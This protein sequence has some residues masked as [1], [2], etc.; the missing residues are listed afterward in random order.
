ME[1]IV[2]KIIISSENALKVTEKISLACLQKGCGYFAGVRSK[3]KD[4]ERFKCQT[5]ANQQTDIAEEW[6]VFIVT[7]G[8]AEQGRCNYTRKE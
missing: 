2:R 4:H 3:L 8:G 7:S 1:R 6:K 5:R